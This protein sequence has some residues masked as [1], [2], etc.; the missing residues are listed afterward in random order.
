MA[1]DLSGLSSRPTTSG[2]HRVGNAS[3]DVSSKANKQEAPS[4]APAETVKLSA[5]AQT[6]RKLEEQVAQLPDVDT[7]RVA[8]IKQ[9]IDDGAYKID[10]ERVAAKLLQLEDQ[11]F[12]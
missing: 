6:L 10:P 7:D 1:I 5:E 2:S 11:L 9:A 12:G 8:R 4:S 3:A